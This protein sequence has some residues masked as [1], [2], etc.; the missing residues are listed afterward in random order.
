MRKLKKIFLNTS[1][2]ELVEM[3]VMMP[4]LFS[5]LLAIF[6]FGRAYNIYGTITQAAIQG[7]RAVEKG[8]QAVKAHGRVRYMPDISPARLR[9]MRSN[10]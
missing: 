9:A 1:G 6:Y 3:A 4:V 7:A 5:V 8:Q 2:N 10:Q